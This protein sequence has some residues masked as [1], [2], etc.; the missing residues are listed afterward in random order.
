MKEMISFGSNSY[1]QELYVFNIKS[2]HILGVIK[3]MLD[4][5]DKDFLSGAAVLGYLI[6]NVCSEK[7]K[8]EIA[9][10]YNNK[11]EE[12]SLFS[13]R[14]NDVSSPKMKRQYPIELKKMKALGKIIKSM[15]SEALTPFY[16]RR[17]Y[18]YVKDLIMYGYIDELKEMK[19]IKN[20]QDLS[21]DETIVNRPF[22]IIEIEEALV[23]Q[24][25]ESQEYKDR[26]N[27]IEALDSDYYK[28]KEI[29]GRSKELRTISDVARDKISALEKVKPKNPNS[30]LQRK[31]EE[32]G[33]ITSESFNESFTLFKE[34]R[35]IVD[36]N[37]SLF[38]NVLGEDF[39]DGN[40]SEYLF[41]HSKEV[42]KPIDVIVR[43][44]INKALKRELPE[45]D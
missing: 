34:Y 25:K 20:Y 6:N 7:E 27:L 40:L 28:M 39:Y 9:D 17:M 22:C 37:G 5:E 12:F 29:D 15:E 30:I 24:I 10:F 18:Y 33:K 31:L 43:H 21:N 16:E 11:L 13:S 41:L 38:N 26:D 45:E 4:S 3:L 23:S 1:G 36:E 8:S 32:L 42:N 35:D 44:T 14:M 19:L 2:S